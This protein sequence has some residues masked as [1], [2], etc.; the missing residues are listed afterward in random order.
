MKKNISELVQS[1]GCILLTIFFT[2]VCTCIYCNRQ[3]SVKQN[4]R[5]TA[6]ILKWLLFHREKRPQPF[7]QIMKE[8]H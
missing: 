1:G 3:E 6:N 4:R 8:Q 7:L 2:E 5:Y